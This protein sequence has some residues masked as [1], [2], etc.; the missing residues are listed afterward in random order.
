MLF[1]SVHFIVFFPV[2]TLLYFMVPHRFRTILLLA[3][4]C[5]FYM[6]FKP[7]YILIL[8]FTITVDYFAGLQ[9]AKSSGVRRKYFLLASIFANV[10]VLSLF[11]YYNFLNLTIASLLH[12]AGV[13]Y[14]PPLLALLLPIGLS[15]HVFQSLSYTIEVYRGN[16]EPEQ[17]FL[18]LA[19]YVMFYP[20]LVAGPI[21][22]PQNL[23]HQF[24][25]EHFFSHTR[26]VRGL[27]L[28][29]YGMFKKV[30]I[31][32]RLAPFVNQVYDHPHEYAGLPL[33]V[34]TLFFA[35]QIYCDFSGY[36]DIAIGSAEVM[37]FTLM[38]N[39]N[40]PYFAKTIAEFWKRWHISLST[41]FRDYVYI[42]LGGNRVNRSR[43][44]ANLMVTFI[45]SGLWHGAN[46]TFVLWGTLNGIYLVAEQLTGYF[47]LGPNPQ[48]LWRPVA[49]ARTFL[50][51]CFA[52]IFFRAAH[53]S[54]GS[55]VAGHLFSGFGELPHLL[56][57][58]T[59]IARSIFLSQ[60]YDEFII[61]VGGIAV[62]LMLEA[63]ER[64]GDIRDL[65]QSQ[66]P[67]V[68]WAAYYAACGAIVFGGAFN[69]S[70]Q[71]IYFQF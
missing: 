68:R 36:S 48:G 18:T 30:F 62:L 55:Y 45:I 9:I 51:T 71:F 39:F 47:G 6:V 63:L 49:V 23:L 37:G 13:R 43:L 33:I 57:S 28:M 22:R 54:D 38:K 32:D 25:E 15:F 67:I 31:A 24:K 70:Q 42:P 40:R 66:S 26:A 52:W 4:S 12:F 10:G 61:A 34:A 56:R 53:I 27:Q 19:L 29:L 59:F 14:I 21:E 58:G 60:P 35:F 69:S 16:Q 7:V 3:A 44:Y 64:K 17:S 46:W 50:L 20:Q 65:L 8:A 41:W 11:K 2:V 1:N 5:Y